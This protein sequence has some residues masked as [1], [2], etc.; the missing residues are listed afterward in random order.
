MST[1]LMLSVLV[2]TRAEPVHA[3]KMATP[4]VSPAADLFPSD[5]ADVHSPGV[6]RDCAALE[7]LDEPDLTALAA[8]ASRHSGLHSGAGG[9]SGSSG[10]VEDV[11]QRTGG[12]SDAAAGDMTAALSR[13]QEVCHHA[14]L[15]WLLGCS[16]CPLWL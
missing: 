13:L 7:G 3:I 1:I 8:A 6:P 5:A 4:R 16:F 10:T 11:A 12:S 2:A 14:L 9:T 15:C